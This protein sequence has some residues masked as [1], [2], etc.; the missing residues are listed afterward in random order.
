MIEPRFTTQQELDKFEK[1]IQEQE[2]KRILKIIDNEIKL[3]EEN[4]FTN[5]TLT[6]NNQLFDIYMNFDSILKQLKKEIEK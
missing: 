2:R 6:H 1:D 5:A 4:C 3:N